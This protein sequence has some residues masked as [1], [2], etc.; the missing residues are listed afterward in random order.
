MNQRVDLDF[1][2][3]VG[4]LPVPQPT[5]GGLAFSVATLPVIAPIRLGKSTDGEPAILF[6]SS[7]RASQRSPIELRHLSVLFGAQCHVSGEVDEEEA[8]FT[9]VRCRGDAVLQGYFLLMARTLL[10]AVGPDPDEIAVEKSVLALVELFRS[11]GKPPAYAVRGL[12]GELLLIARSVDPVSVLRAWHIAAIERFDFGAGDKRVEVK[13]AG[14]SSRRHH[15]S[16]EQLVVAGLDVCVASIQV[17]PSAAGQSLTE[18]VDAIASRLEHVDDVLRLTTTV[19]AV[20]GTDW[21]AYS[22][23]RFDDALAASSV[24]FYRAEAVPRVD[25][26]VPIAVTQVEFVSDLSGVAVLANADLAAAGGLWSA[27]RPV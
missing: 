12:W 3:V 22:T 4:A 19:G 8:Y 11:A 18:L 25:L 14:R 6:A 26:P 9:V 15:F 21:V 13:T 27:I 16:L 23:A 7:Q 17:E 24:R 1:V 10:L 20:L 2:S 5:R